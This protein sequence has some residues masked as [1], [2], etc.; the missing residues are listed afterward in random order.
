M[1]VL[2]S[3]ALH[4]CLLAWGFLAPSCARAV[5]SGTGFML[6]VR[7]EH[8][9]YV[10]LFFFFCPALSVGVLS[11]PPLRRSVGYLQELIGQLTSLCHFLSSFAILITL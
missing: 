1:V 6:Q 10:R 9:R 7:M 4:A 3:L 11:R 2:F 8:I 5:L